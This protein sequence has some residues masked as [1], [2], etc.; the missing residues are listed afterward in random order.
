MPALSE[1]K[2]HLPW[3]QAT[4]DAVRRKKSFILQYQG[5]RYFVQRGGF[6]TPI[7]ADGKNTGPSVHVSKLLAPDKDSRPSTKGGARHGK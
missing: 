6:A 2:T 1:L 4:A 5:V 3:S 7:D